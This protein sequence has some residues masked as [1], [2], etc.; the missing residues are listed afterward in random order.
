M[1][2]TPLVPEGRQLINGYGDGRFR[3]AGEVFE[4]GVLVFTETTV[5]WPVTTVD[6]ISIDALE[7][8]VSADPSV[9][10]L[11]IGCGPKF[12]MPPKVLREELRAAGISMEWMDT[13]AACR[14]FNVLLSE[15]RRVAA[16]LIAVA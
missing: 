5:P 1:D 2:I 10:I 7:P 6:E 8:I 12:L 9:D 13:G 16:A 15:E 14:T 11:L 4:S 3:I